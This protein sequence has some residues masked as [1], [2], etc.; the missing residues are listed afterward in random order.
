MAESGEVGGGGAFAEHL[1]DGIAGDEMDEKEDE[2]DYNP[3]DGE[4]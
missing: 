3:D 2:R 1:F 4:G